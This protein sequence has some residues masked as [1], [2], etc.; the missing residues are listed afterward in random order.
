MLEKSMY[1][2]WP[3]RICIFIKGKKHGK[4][5]LR[6]THELTEA[7]QLQ[8]DCDIQVTN[9]ILHGLPPDVYALVNHQEEAKDIWDRVKML[10]KGTKLSYQER[11][12]RLYNLFDKCDHVLVNTKFLNALPSEWSK[13]VT[14]VKLVKSMYTTNYDQLY[15]YLSQHEQHANE[16]HINRERYPDSLAFVVNSPT[17]YN[18]SQSP[19]YLSYSMYPPP[20]QFT[21][22]YVAPIHHQHHNTPVNPQHHLVSPLP[23]ISPSMTPQS[24]AEF[25]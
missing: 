15:A 14:N 6:N 7:Q 18:L 16:V 5:D 13:F 25:P 23:F 8:D 9:I 20:Q 10:I 17:L 4:L 21:P 3:S 2:S 12:C 11:E 22:V 19:Q 1:D 24:Q